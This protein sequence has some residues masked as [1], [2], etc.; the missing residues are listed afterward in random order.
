MKPGQSM[1][2]CG[3]AFWPRQRWIHEAHF[4]SA[5]SRVTLPSVND[6]RD[7]SHAVVNTTAARGTG[8]SRQVEWQRE[9]RARYNEKMR[10]YMVRWR[11]A[12]RASGATA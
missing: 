3:E 11:A 7:V 10:G 9:N 8:A 4:S 1:C 5:L 2:S 12:R 6:A